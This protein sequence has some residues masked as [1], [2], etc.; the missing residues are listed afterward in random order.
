MKMSDDPTLHFDI[1]Q[2]KGTFLYISF[3]AVLHFTATVGSSKMSFYKK[4]AFLSIHILSV[5]F[6]RFVALYG[7]VSSHHQSNSPMEYNLNNIKLEMHTYHS[8]S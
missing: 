4:I 8:E 5:I 7:Y 3:I 1:N 2:G 6:G